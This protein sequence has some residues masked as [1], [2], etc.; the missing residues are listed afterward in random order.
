M[1]EQP[2][3]GDAIRT[4]YSSAKQIQRERT[5]RPPRGHVAAPSWTMEGVPAETRF[6]GRCL[7]CIDPMGD[8]EY[9]ESK[10]IIGVHGFIE[11][12][13]GSVTVGWYGN[14]GLIHAG[15]EIAIDG[16]IGNRV[17]L[18]EPYIID[19][20]IMGGE[21]IVPSI[22]AVDGSP[23]GLTCAAIVETVPL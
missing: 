3:Q 21:F 12:G 18:P 9:P 6:F 20:G 22:T 14:Y 5:R 17:L 8:G 10:R 19:N 11:G 13:T 4:L 7:I 16:E 2:Q 15:H 1:A 23:I